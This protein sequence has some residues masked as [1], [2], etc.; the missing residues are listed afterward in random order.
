MSATAK[1]IE[2][3]PAI[4]RYKP[5]TAVAVLAAHAQ[6]MQENPA[7]E[8]K[9]VR[10]DG[11]EY[12]KTQGMPTPRLE[13][14]KFSNLIPAIKNHSAQ[15][16]VANITM[17]GDTRFVTSEMDN[18]PPMGEDRYQDSALWHLNDAFLRDVTV[19]A[20]PDN[21]KGRL[22]LI[23]SGQDGHFCTLRMVVKLGR[24]AEL[25]L[26]E[27]YAGAG[28]VSPLA[29]IM[30]A[31]NAVLR[32]VTTQE[33]D[34]SAVCTRTADIQIG[35]DATYE[36]FVLNTGAAFARHQVHARLTSENATANLSGI[37]LLR[38]QQTGDNT[39]LVEHSA[40]QG[41]SRQFFRAVIGDQARGV[42]QGKIHVHPQAQKTDGY[43]LSNALL[44][45]EVA[46]MDTKPELEIYADDVKC[47]HGATTGQLDD[48]AL[49]YLRSRG[50]P[51]SEARALLIE[52][53]LG[54][55]VACV[56]DEQ[57]KELLR[58]KVRAWLG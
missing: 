43:Q 50:V 10:Q 24:G 15:C 33:Q 42:F 45:S 1:K 55:V 37:T 54:E 39:V 18:I 57:M 5:E 3:F 46:E 28:W 32:H 20:V 4:N 35:R 13:R 22:E 14:W 23:I 9:S 58:E 47:S 41:S 7:P 34:I 44:L 21:Q 25:T 12:L 52:G 48:E 26:I 11:V 6:F 30:L 36:S 8:L 49:F 16:G 53:F 17:S 40:P 2:N 56:T 51:E 27:S 19:I 38:G 31:D 29:Q